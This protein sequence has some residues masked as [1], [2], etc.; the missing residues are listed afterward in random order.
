MSLIHLNSTRFEEVI[1]NGREPCLVI[2]SRKTCHVCQGVVPILE[3]IQLI[4]SNNES[5][6]CSF[7]KESIKSQLT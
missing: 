2:F 7:I 4:A 3:D 5:L 1:Y 6:D